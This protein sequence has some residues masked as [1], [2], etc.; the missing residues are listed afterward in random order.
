M[1]LNKT[2]KVD[3]VES[4]YKNTKCEKYVVQK[5]LD[6]F[7]EQMK[8]SLSKGNDIELRGFG[9]FEMRLRKGRENARNPKTGEKL[10]SDSHYVV[11]FRSG[12]DL[13]ESVLK[14]PIKEN[15]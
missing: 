6:E 13:K 5:V 9:T 2:T 7:F 8:I 15:L 1:S 14:L 12:K 4:I 11:A 3:L 10:S